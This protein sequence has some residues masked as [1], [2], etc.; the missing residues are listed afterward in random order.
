MN[1]TEQD[2]YRAEWDARALAEAEEIKRDTARAQRATKAAAKLVTDE[3]RRLDALRTVAAKG[4]KPQAASSARGM[5]DHLP[6][7]PRR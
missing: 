6:Q 3:Q 7:L 1:K 4:D 5:N 2:N